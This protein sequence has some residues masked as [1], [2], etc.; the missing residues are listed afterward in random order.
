MLGGRVAN[1]Y[2][3]GSHARGEASGESDVDLI[4]VTDTKR[5][6]PE[7]GKDFLDVVHR[8]GA[9]D[10]LIY[11]P[12]EWAHMRRRPSGFWRRVRREAI[13]VFPQHRRDR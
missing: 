4:L 1:A 6:F 10:L 13:S 8:L 3:F 11:T 12:A 9:V 7:R 5:P 2:L